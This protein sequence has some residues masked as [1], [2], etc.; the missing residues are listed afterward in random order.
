M[1][2]CCTDPRHRQASRSEPNI[3]LGHLMMVYGVHS[4]AT[5][6]FRIAT[7]VPPTTEFVSNLQTTIILRPRAS[8]KPR[9]SQHLTQRATTTLR[10]ALRRTLSNTFDRVLQ[11]FARDPCRYLFSD[12]VYNPSFVLNCLSVRYQPYLIKGGIL[13]KRHQ[14][15]AS[16][17]MSAG[18]YHTCLQ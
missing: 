11:P 12:D 7:T 4:S 14:P 5:P 13:P 15:K 9:C 1:T 2:G 10:S 6:V 17:K 18:A 3:R 16:G 8:P